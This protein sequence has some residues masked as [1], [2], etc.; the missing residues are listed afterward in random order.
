M[1]APYALP[2]STQPI[3]DPRV[4]ALAPSPNY[5]CALPMLACMDLFT[6]PSDLLSLVTSRATTLLR[7]DP[8][9]RGTI[10][11]TPIPMF[12]S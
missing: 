8:R 3:A 1:A 2:T 4:L 6:R 9:A 12:T 5:P 7:V 11:G 10:Q